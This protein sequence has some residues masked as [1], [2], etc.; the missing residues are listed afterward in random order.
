MND[1]LYFWFWFD[2]DCK[3]R[4]PRCSPGYAKAVVAGDPITCP[5]LVLCELLH[6]SSSST[7]WT[8][9]VLWKRVWTGEEDG[10]IKELGMNVWIGVN[11]KFVFSGAEV[12]LYQS[13]LGFRV[14]ASDFETCHLKIDPTEKYL[15]SENLPGCAVQLGSVASIIVTKNKQYIS[16][17]L[18]LGYYFLVFLKFDS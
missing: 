10:G 15:I 16:I 18:F 2:R 13:A 7:R 5:S 1:S 12:F 4:D 11:N 8:G 3:S 6:F 14:S 9:T 17:F